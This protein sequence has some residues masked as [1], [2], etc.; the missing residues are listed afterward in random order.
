VPHI[1]SQQQSSVAMEELLPHGA[2]INAY[3]KMVDG[4]ARRPS[5]RIFYVSDT[6]YVG[7]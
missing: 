4:K 6:C 7:M 1:S 2:Q 3:W 5:L